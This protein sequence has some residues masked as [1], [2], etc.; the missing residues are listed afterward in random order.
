MM[1]DK[2]LTKLLVLIA[3]SISPVPA[4]SQDTPYFYGFRLFLIRSSTEYKQLV[5]WFGEV[6]QK[7]RRAGLRELTPLL[8]KPLTLAFSIDD[9]GNITHI[10]V[11]CTSGSVEMDNK[12]IELVKRAAP[13]AGAKNSEP[14][15][16][17]I[18]VKFRREAD[19]KVSG[20][21]ID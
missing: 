12:F 2:S 18:S 10:E 17:A 9:R 11:I 8:E 15:Y 13:F 14:Q 16:R 20:F 21:W 19:V 7:V 1:L 4:L 5:P 3:L 6:E